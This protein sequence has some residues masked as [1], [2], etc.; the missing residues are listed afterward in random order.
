M[1]IIIG[2]SPKGAGGAS[3]PPGGRDEVEEEM[4]SEDINLGVPP[5]LLSDDVMSPFQSKYSPTKS[6]V[7]GLMCV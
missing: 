4:L 6:I 2:V 5:N 7:S 3:A 1:A